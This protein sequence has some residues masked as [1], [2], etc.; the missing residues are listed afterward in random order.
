MLNFRTDNASTNCSLSQ[1][2]TINK[3]VD[4]SKKHGLEYTSLFEFL[5][6]KKIETPKGKNDEYKRVGNRRCTEYSQVRFNNINFFNKEKL[7]F[8][9][10][11]I[12][13]RK[14]LK[15]KLNSKK[16]ITVLPDIEFLTNKNVQE[17]TTV[18]NK[19]KIISSK[20]YPSLEEKLNYINLIQKNKIIPKNIKT[21]NF[22]ASVEKKFLVLSNEKFVF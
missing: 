16:K 12:S 8:N 1:V 19:T 20:N 21:R 5:K 6:G 22:N 15:E 18:K 11:I 13:L 14:I 9:K 4:I 3:S 2:S 10:R 17:I 7:E